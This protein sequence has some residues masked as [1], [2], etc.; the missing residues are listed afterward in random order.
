[1]SIDNSLRCPLGH[2]GLEFISED[3]PTGV[4]QDGY[5]EY[6]HEEGYHCES[7]GHVYDVEDVDG[8]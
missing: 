2:R 3:F 7:C 5:R 8:D 4:E 6:Q 1:V